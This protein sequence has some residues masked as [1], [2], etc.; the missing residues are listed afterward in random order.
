MERERKGE[1]E[2]RV[3]E[4]GSEREGAPPHRKWFAPCL[5]QSDQREHIA[6]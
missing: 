4:E 2:E 3:G 1:E 6:Q 5:L